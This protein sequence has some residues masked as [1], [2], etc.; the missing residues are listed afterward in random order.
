M[1]PARLRVP[2]PAPTHSVRQGRRGR[3]RERRRRS[4][5]A[6]PMSTREV[7]N[8]N[9]CRGEPKAAAWP[10]GR[11]PGGRGGP[12]VLGPE[13]GRLPLPGHALHSCCLCHG[14]V[15]VPLCSGH[16]S[17]VPLWLRW[18]QVTLKHSGVV[19]ARTWEQVRRAGGRRRVSSTPGLPRRCCCGPQGGPPRTTVSPGPGLRG[20]GCALPAGGTAGSPASAPA[21]AQA[22]PGTFP[23]HLLPPVGPRGGPGAWVGPT[24]WRRLSP[25]NGSA[26]APPTFRRPGR[27]WPTPAS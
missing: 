7:G 16:C 26:G 12:R 19:K 25:E 27:S 17:V 21:W 6:V 15:C 13:L 18:P 10:L 3:S 11:R 24:P 9:V 23:A 4:H 20:T 22:A 1:E 2:V 14:E 5:A 8:G